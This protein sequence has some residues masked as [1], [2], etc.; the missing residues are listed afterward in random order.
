MAIQPNIFRCPELRC[1]LA[2]FTSD[3][4]TFTSHIIFRQMFGAVFFPEKKRIN[5]DK[6]S[7]T[8]ENTAQTRGMG[9]LEMRLS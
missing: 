5:Q 4:R 7:G 3:F 6:L 1:I 8:P 9:I 2:R